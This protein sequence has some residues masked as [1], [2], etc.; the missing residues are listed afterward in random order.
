LSSRTISF[1][2]RRT[3]SL[4]DSFSVMMVGDR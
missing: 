2:I 3:Q 1:E 4:D